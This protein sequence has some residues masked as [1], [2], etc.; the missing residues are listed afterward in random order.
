MFI[1]L[2]KGNIFTVVLNDFSNLSQAELQALK[3]ED[4]LKKVEYMTYKN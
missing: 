2:K 4:C 1:E 3:P